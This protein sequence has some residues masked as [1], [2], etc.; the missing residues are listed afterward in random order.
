[1]LI[2]NIVVALAWV[3]LGDTISTITRSYNNM[4]N[5]LATTNYGETKSDEGGWMDRC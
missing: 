2:T 1:M 4:I 3:Q 5:V